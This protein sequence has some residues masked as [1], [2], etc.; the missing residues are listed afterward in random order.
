MC[1]VHHYC[2]VYLQ[3]SG[4]SISVINVC[5]TCMFSWILLFVFTFLLGGGCFNTFYFH[6]FLICCYLCAWDILSNGHFHVRWLLIWFIAVF[7]C[8]LSPYNILNW[9]EVL[10]LISSLCCILPFCRSQWTMAEGNYT[11][12]LFWIGIIN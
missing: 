12:S 6:F 5:V 10:T 3:G 2:Y 8:S 1:L 7:A 4:D 11:L 9:H